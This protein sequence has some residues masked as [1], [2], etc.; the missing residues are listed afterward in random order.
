MA[1]LFSHVQAISL[2]DII[3]TDIISCAC[4]GVANSYTDTVNYVVCTHVLI[5]MHAHHNKNYYIAISSQL[6]IIN[7]KSD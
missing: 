5:T 2:V 1:L 4:M 7:T 6:M 3:L